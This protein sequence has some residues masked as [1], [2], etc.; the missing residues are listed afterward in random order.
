MPRKEQNIGVFDSGI[1][2]L[3]VA[4][5]IAQRL[6]QERLIYFGDTEHLPYGEKSPEAI[7]TWA[8]EIVKFLMQKEI[9]MIVIACNSI[10]S[11]AYHQIRAELPDDILLVDVIHPAV[12]YIVAKNYKSVGI[13]GTRAT[14]SSKIHTRQI[15]A[16]SPET[17]VHTLAT[18]LLVPMIEEGY[19]DNKIS[20]E[21]IDNYL[22]HPPFQNIE[23]LLL[24]CTHYP[25]IKDEIDAYWQGKVEVIDNALVVAEL[26]ATQL[27][28]AGLLAD[29]NSQPSEF[30]VSDYTYSFEQTAQMFFGKEISIY[31][32]NLWEV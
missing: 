13:I 10:S 8:L 11:Y 28:K 21:I 6:P 3:T 12:D 1:G 7:R 22:S 9:K 17:E 26:I 2:G 16:R 23:A 32:S 24:A 29:K 25:L 19:F 14:I 5:A 4:R 31:P 27:K 15:S 18:P 20:H 30:Y